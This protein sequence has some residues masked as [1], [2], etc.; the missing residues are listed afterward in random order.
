MPK[1]PRKTEQTPPS[2]A[3]GVARQD[4]TAKNPEQLEGV[5][6]ASM[7]QRSSTTPSL[8]P[9]TGNCAQSS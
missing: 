8:V 4:F 3:A 7:V 2:Q 5:S 9:T 1:V 6:F